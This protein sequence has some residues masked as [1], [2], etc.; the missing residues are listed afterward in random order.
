MNRLP[1][2]T[3]GR[4]LALGVAVVL[5]G[6][7]YAVT[8]APLLS[9]Y[10]NGQEAVVEGQARKAM[11]ERS[12]HDLPQLRKMAAAW[13]DEA[14]ANDLLLPASSDA[15]AAATLQST[16][17][18]LVAQGG[19]SLSSTEILPP[20][21]EDRFRRVGIHISFSGDQRLLTTVLGGIETARPLLFV[22]D[23]D[24]RGTGQPGVADPTLT[25]AFD[26]FGFPAR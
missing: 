21:N 25:V 19:A 20:Q 1:E 2:G 23:L 15:I 11:L 14:P 9:L 17:K 22:D 16:I 7:I 3:A 13:K 26:V 12:V 10:A 18:D 4:A 8:V 6:F 5:L 24:I